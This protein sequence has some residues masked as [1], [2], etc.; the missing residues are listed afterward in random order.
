MIINLKSNRIA[1]RRLSTY[2]GDIGVGTY[3]DSK[4]RYFKMLFD[5]G[6]CE[7]WIPSEKCITERCKTHQRYTISQSFEE[8]KGGI[9]SI[10]VI[11]LY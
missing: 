8:I 4:I 5:T 3:N 2:Y 1:Q 7:F 6:S 9:V 10:Q 11:K